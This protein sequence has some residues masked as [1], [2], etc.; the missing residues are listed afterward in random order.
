MRRRLIA[1]IGTLRVRRLLFIGGTMSIAVLLCLVALAALLPTLISTSQAQSFLRLSL[2]K[3]MNRPVSWS[4][5]DV[6]W[7]RGL[8]LSG[9]TLGNGA[10]PLLNASVGDLGV[11]PG[12]GRNQSGKWT[13]RL[14]VKINRLEARLA[15]GPKKPPEKKPAKDPLT[16][17][18]EAVQKFQGMEFPLPVD[19][20]L[21][22]DVLPVSIDYVDP[23]S[24][25]TVAMK[26][27]AVRLA[28]PSLAKLPIDLAVTGNVAAGKGKPQRVSV[29]ARLA[30]LVTTKE[31]IKPAAALLT[32][33]ASLPGLAFGADGGLNR[34][35]GFHAKLGLDLPKLLLVAAPFAPKPLPEVTGKV[36]INLKADADKSGDLQL[37]LDVA[38]DRLGVARLP[39]K[40]LPLGPLDVRLHQKV[41]SDHKRQKV[42]FAEGNLASPGLASV[43]WGA[44]VDRPTERSRVVNAEVGPVRV[45]LARARELAAPFLPKSVEELDGAV[46]IRKVT[47]HLTGPGNDGEVTVENA[48]VDLSRLRLRSAAGRVEG[49]GI[50]VAL[51]RAVV[52][53]RSMTPTK[54]TADLSWG[55]RRFETA[56][57]KR[58]GVQGGR[59]TLNLKLDELDLKG[60]AKPRAVVDATQALAFDVL[61]V[62]EE[63]S[64]DGL[65]EELTLKARALG[66]GEL[67]ASLPE[68]KVEIA[69]VQSNSAGKKV[70]LRPVAATLSAEGVHIPQKGK[71]N[72]TV[73]HAACS[74]SAAD[75]LQL[76]AEASLTGL[77]KQAAA[78]KGSVNVDLGRIL[79]VAAPFLPAGLTAS[80][81]TAATW[82]CAL[83]LPAK[84]P[85][86][87]R[88][89]LR[90]AK[91]GLALLERGEVTV[92][93][94]D[95]DLRLP[96]K[97]GAYVVKGLST[98]PQLRF[99]APRA[100]EPVAVDAAFRFGSV[101]GLSGSAA[102]L[103]VQ[104][105]TLTLQGE[106]VQWKELRLNEEFKLASLHLS[107]VAD[108]TVSRIDSLLEDQ[109]QFDAATLLKRLD[110]TMF[111]HLEGN[112][113]RRPTPVLPGLSLSGLVSAGARVDLTAARELRLRG[114]T[115]CRDLGVSNGKGMTA[116]GIKA[117]LVVDRAYAL[118]QGKGDSWVPLS[119]ALVRPAPLVREERRASDLAS[120]IYEDLRGESSGPRKV[121]VKSAYFKSGPFPLEASALEADL[122][123]EPEA[124]GLSFFQAE[125]G[126]GTVRAR[127]MID[128][129]REVPV[130]TTSCSFSRLDPAILFPAAGAGAPGGDGELTGEMS[131]SAPLAADQR[132]FLEGLRMNLNLRR[133]SSR[134]LD[135]ALSALDPYQRNEKIVAQ[136][137][138]LKLADL[139]GLRVTAVDGA[140]D[141]EG[142]LLIKGAAIDI[143]KVERLRLSELPLKKEL[144]QVMSGI[145]TSRVLLDLARAD[146][147]VIGSKGELSLKRRKP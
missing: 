95:L 73:A 45:E 138:S 96:T 12:F 116:S 60:P 2:S 97:Q 13:V 34:P 122:L 71:G 9:L 99:A 120:R 29:G 141:C 128:L 49:E 98:A 27:F 67:E 66:G 46:S 76:A 101:S 1:Y 92:R 52:P 41:V 145:T 36:A 93:L 106:L 26:D 111:A 79:P 70:A 109:G 91:S 62:G 39:G 82:D 42:T 88:N 144:A 47:A 11:E 136:R 121:G 4:R 75:A 135:R 146:T 74:V 110:A 43:S 24:R 118:A 117:D 51:D 72:P 25:R 14:A 33:D 44:V 89:P 83:P 56:G 31:R 142:E 139:K 38:G 30:E 35:G 8:A 32:A 28:V 3:A 64:V 104:G 65:R 137:K 126:G 80:G 20:A 55:G 133:F 140:L 125:V 85:G 86:A 15:P 127:G 23:A 57:K 131:L 107:Q 112:F 113:P 16:T 81:R 17:A 129:A 87:D 103:P 132:A 124:L 100:G 94:A 53:L 119:A 61:K 21:S 143:P 18:A 69:S 77:A 6:S 59:G 123:L 22:V 48:G 58:I 147:L 54:V 40:G 90:R 105:G 134:V 102:N 84:A 78:T 5:L 10:A 50:G 19:V 115:K 108:I 63:L 37:L 114:Y 7:S 130:L 68:M